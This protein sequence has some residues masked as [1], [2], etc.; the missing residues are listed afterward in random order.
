ME[1][2]PRYADPDIDS[3]YQ[4][5][6]MTISQMDNYGRKPIIGC[7]PPIEVTGLSSPVVQV[8]EQQNNEILYT[9]RIKGNIFTPKVFKKGLYTVKVGEP[10]TKKLKV[11]KD[12]YPVACKVGEKIKVKF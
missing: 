9:L 1:C 7:L 5:W 6:P 4:G 11:F 3:Q 10:G 12:I 8:V 2:W